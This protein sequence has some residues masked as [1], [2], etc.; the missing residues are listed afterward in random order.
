[1]SSTAK[2]TWRM[3]GVFAGA[4]PITASAR[5]GVKLNQFEPSVAVRGPHHREL[6]A[7]A[8]ESYHAVHPTVLD[9]SLALQLE[10]EVD[11]ERGRGREVGDHDVHVAHALD[12]HALD[13]RDTTAPAAARAR[14]A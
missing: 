3:P 6:H 4:L 12:R 1:M 9:Q 10:S 8:R 11:E 7:D 13:G 2:Q 14:A 5:R